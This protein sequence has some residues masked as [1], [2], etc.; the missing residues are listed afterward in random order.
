MMNTT[1]DLAKLAASMGLRVIHET[2]VDH[3]D[4]LKYTR[5]KVYH[6]VRHPYRDEENLITHWTYHDQ[7][8]QGEY[9]DVLAKPYND[10]KQFE[11]WK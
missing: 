11:R 9:M 7:M 10:L 4:R 8:D 5:F 6:V 3:A 1:Y 2:W